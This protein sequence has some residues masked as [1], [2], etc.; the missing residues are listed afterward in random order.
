MCPRCCPQVDLHRLNP[1]LPSRWSEVLRNSS[2]VV[3][4]GLADKGLSAEQFGALADA[5]RHNPVWRGWT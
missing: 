2:A 3:T 4:I 1:R 5:L